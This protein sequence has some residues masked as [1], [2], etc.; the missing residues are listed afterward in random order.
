ML[1]YKKLLI[2]FLV[3]LLS[4]CGE[5]EPKSEVSK[6]EK[7][8]V[9]LEEL[10]M[11]ELK[12]LGSEKVAEALGCKYEELMEDTLY[13]NLQPHFTFGKAL[14]TE[15]HPELGRAMLALWYDET[16][17]NSKFYF[18]SDGTLKL[19]CNLNSLGT[20]DLSAVKTLS[21][22]EKR[23]NFLYE[24]ICKKIGV[25]PF[26]DDAP[27]LLA[28]YLGKADTFETL[29][30]VLRRQ[31]IVLMNFGIGD[32]PPSLYRLDYPD[33]GEN[34]EGGNAL[35]S[36]DEFYILIPRYERQVI[37][38]L[39]KKEEVDGKEIAYG[40]EAPIE[41]RVPVSLSFSSLAVENFFGK[42]RELKN[43]TF[44]RDKRLDFELETDKNGKLSNLPKDILDISD[45][46]KNLN[47]IEEEDA[48]W[49]YSEILEELSIFL[50]NGPRG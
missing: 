15:A 8:D 16:V 24:N 34:M 35:L 26:S 38:L 43:I 47:P 25:D 2:I 12:N 48:E 28:G 10:S 20:F 18:H 21:H 45:Y 44:Y 29:E 22:P 32:T 31:T 23:I 30:D 42:E 40:K 37:A 7:R 46:I 13:F 19:S 17:K 14:M 3:I 41:S 39:K 9:K 1:N 36:G 6:K 11:E 4:A 27:F 50:P 33:D 5:K 49:F